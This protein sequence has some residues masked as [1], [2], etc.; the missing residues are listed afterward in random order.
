MQ[1]E[2]QGRDVNKSQLIYAKVI[3]GG[4]IFM[5]TSILWISE[6]TF[7]VQIL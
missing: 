3:I 4:A 5:Y 1:V 6:R 7:M 2:T